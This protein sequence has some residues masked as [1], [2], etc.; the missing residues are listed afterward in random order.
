MQVNNKII[1]NSNIITQTAS[2][3]NGNSNTV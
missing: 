1:V 3:L 2:N